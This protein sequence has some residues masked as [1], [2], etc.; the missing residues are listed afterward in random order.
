MS[1][2]SAWRTAWLVLLAGLGAFEG[3]SILDGNPETEPLTDFFV[4][5]VPIAVGL[6]LVVWIAGW[7]I[8]HFRNAYRDQE[9][10]S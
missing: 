6:P 3:W 7:L 4:G 8:R 10:G 1:R 9:G 5:V 2:R